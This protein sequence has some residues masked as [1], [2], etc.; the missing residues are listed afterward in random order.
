MYRCT[1]PILVVLFSMACQR[2]HEPKQYELQGQILAIQPERN[3]V[4]IKHGDI[5]GFMPGMT[6]PFKVKDADLLSGNRRAIS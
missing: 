4:L 2:G 5:K 6:M 3:E 1:V